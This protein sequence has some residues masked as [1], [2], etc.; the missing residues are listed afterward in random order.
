MNLNNYSAIP[1]CLTA[2]WRNGSVSASYF[3]RFQREV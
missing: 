1:D 2:L 3:Y